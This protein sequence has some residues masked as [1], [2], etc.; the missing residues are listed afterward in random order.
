MNATKLQT[1][2]PAVLRIGIG[3][4]IL[5]FGV[6]MFIDTQTWMSYIPQ[7]ATDLTGLSLE[8]LT[9]INGVIE[10]TLSLCL[11][12]GVFVRTAAILMAVHIAFIALELGYNQIAIRDW[13]LALAALSIFFYGADS[14]SLQK[15]F[16]KKSEVV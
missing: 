16:T 14:W 11:I 1:Y 2:A 7:Y 15:G 5:W 3:L 6:Q 4:T 12:L 9:Y 13:G 10:V 8:Q